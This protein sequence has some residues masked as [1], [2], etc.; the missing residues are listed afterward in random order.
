MSCNC[1]DTFS[2]GRDSR[3]EAKKMKNNSTMVRRNDHDHHQSIGLLQRPHKIVDRRQRY[4]LPGLTEAA[5]KIGKG[6]DQ[7]LLH[8][9]G[10][11]KTNL[12]APVRACWR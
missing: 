5:R 8:W 9:S 11:W 1:R 4:H 7:I 12:S 2:T 6:R 10:D 3:R